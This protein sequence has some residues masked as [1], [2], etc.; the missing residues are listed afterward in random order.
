MFVSI[1]TRYVQVVPAISD[2]WRGRAEIA[3]LS[4]S[5]LAIGQESDP[6]ATLC[7]ETYFPLCKPMFALYESHLLRASNLLCRFLVCFNSIA[8]IIHQC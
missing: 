2:A 1:V 6:V 8:L 4:T 5:R 7:L 3:S